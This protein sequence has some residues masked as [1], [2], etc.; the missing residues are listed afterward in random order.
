MTNTVNQKRFRIDPP[1]APAVRDDIVPALPPIEYVPS[2]TFAELDLQFADLS[3][4]ELCA[5]RP[6]RCDENPVSLHQVGT[7]LSTYLAEMQ[8]TPLLDPDSEY[9]LFRWMNYL[10][11]RAA[12]FDRADEDSVR[13]R[14]RCLK[15]A[16]KVRNRIVSAN[17]RLVVSIAKK[18]VDAYNSLED[19]ISEGNLPLIRAVEI[20]DFERGNK[21]STYATWAIRNGL[22]R[23]IPRNRR[24]MA[25]AMTGVD[26]LLPEVVDVRSET[27]GTESYQSELRDAVEQMLAGLPERDRQIVAARFGLNG[28]DREFRFREIAESLGVSTERVRQLL[29]RTLRELSQRRHELSLELV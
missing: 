29:S 16:R 25:F 20:F 9:Q 12:K 19:L 3:I 28:E 15:A 1:H 4:R 17:L 26:E 6:V 11:Y 27:R 22:N 8:R 24:R 21:F 14:R 10:R 18:H 2:P 13:Q 23:S 5:H 7:G